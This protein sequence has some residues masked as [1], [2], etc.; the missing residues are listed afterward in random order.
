MSTITLELPDKHIQVLERAAQ[1]RG[2]TVNQIVSEL[3]N[4]LATGVGVA[5]N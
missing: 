2:A 1:E 5:G 3:V 4:I